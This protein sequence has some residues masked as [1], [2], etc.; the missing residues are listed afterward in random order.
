[1]ESTNIMKTGTTTVG[2]VYKGGI[3]LAADKRVT[4]GNFIPNK[5]VE[6]V[7]NVTDSIAVTIAGT[8]SDAMFLIKLMRSELKLKSIRTGIDPSVQQAANFAARM[9]FQ[10]IR[11]PS[12]IPGITH[13][14]MAGN[15]ESGN[16]LY[17]I[18]P[19]GSI[20][21][22]KDYISSGS[23]SVMAYGVLET[24]YKPDM[25]EDEAMDLAIKCIN[26]AIQRDTASGQGIDVFAVNDKGAKRIFEKELEYKITK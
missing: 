10:N 9:V 21:A 11:T 3:I 18:F 13:F 17:D 19:D 1:M 20:S 22:I 26:A 7:H 14:L 24:L 25:T 12:M 6:K 4:T 15:D 16:Y 23:G 2:I 5:S 8:A